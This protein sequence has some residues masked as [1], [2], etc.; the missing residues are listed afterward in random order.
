[1]QN[2]IVYKQ[3]FTSQYFRFSLADQ[4]NDAQ[5]HA[6]ILLLSSLHKIGQYDKMILI[7]NLGL[8]N[9]DLPYKD[10]FYFYEGLALFEMGQMD[11]A[12]LLF[13]KS[14]TIEKGN[15]DVYY[16]IADIYQKAGQLEQAKD[17]LQV[18]YALHQKNDPRFP[19]E[20]KTELRFF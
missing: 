12:F 9:Q 1:M 15:A 17:F 7:S 13:Q 4:I 6:Y 5:G 16:Y 20:A 19:Y 11:K 2:S 14:I 10:A 18:S 3:I 8:A